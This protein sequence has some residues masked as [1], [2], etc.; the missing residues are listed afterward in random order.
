MTEELFLPLAQHA[1]DRDYL[2]RERERP[3]GALLAESGTRVLPMW[4]GQVLLGGYEFGSPELNL[5]SPDLFTENDFLI[6]LGRAQQSTSQLRPGSAVLLA[7]LDEALINRLDLAEAQWH[8]LRK[9]GAGLS[10]IDV[11]LF[12]QGL[13]LAN[14]H[15][16]HQHCPNCG[17][18]TKI[19][20]AGWVRVCEQD[21]KELFP[22]TDPAVIVA[23]I[24]GEERILLGSQGV[25]EEN[26]WSILAGFVEPGE[27]LNA[28]VI[29][30]MK[31]E[32]GILVKNPKFL[33]S[34]AWP[35]PYSLMLGFTAE[36]ASEAAAIEPDGVEIQKLRWFSRHELSA[37]VGSLIL[38]SKIAIARSIIEH[39]FGGPLVCQGEEAR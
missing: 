25:W 12:T 28:A 33:G 11:G 26:R 31:E 36:L 18:L 32:A 35:F 19:S 23:V 9:S 29:R 13:A 1:V 20:R 4:Q 27:S 22:R 15:S 37:E 34:Q 5:L 3:I 30:E 24:D 8:H 38:P 2:S 21:G 16:S 7:P 10:P 14:W 39:W 6:F 17:S